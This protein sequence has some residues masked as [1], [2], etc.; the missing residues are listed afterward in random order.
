MRRFGANKIMAAVY[1]Y[2][3]P[4][5]I[6][7]LSA[8]LAEDEK[9]QQWRTYM[10]DMSCGMIHRWSKKSTVPFF[11]DMKK[12]VAG[13]KDDRTGREIVDDLRAE[14]RKRK[15]QRSKK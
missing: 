2:G 9:L 14:W 3:A 5:S 8:L 1:R 4:P 7:A 11:S 6:N 12:K 15:L 13:K 10:A